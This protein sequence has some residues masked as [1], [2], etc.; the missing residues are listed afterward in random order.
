MNGTCARCPRRIFLNAGSLPQGR[1]TCRPCRRALGGVA[2]SADR[3]RRA[4]HTMYRRTCEYCSSF[5]VCRPPKQRFCSISH[6]ALARNGG[7]SS[8]PGAAAKRRRTAAP[9][10]STRAIRALGSRWRRQRRECVYCGFPCQQV[11]HVVP[12]S[13]GGTNGEGNLAPACFR[14]NNHKAGRLVIEWLAEVKRL[15]Q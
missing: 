4:A 10:L 15:T 8:T 12:L 13:R 1:A 7:P 5:F 14:C 9:G 2:T 11:D 3:V 6:A